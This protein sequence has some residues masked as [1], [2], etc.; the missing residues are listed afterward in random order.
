MSGL[1]WVS[2]LLHMKLIGVMGMLNQRG[3]DDGLGGWG[4]EGGT[5]ES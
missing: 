2:G 1:L 5:I 4:G 3:R